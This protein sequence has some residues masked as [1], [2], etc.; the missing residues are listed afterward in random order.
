MIPPTCEAKLACGF[1]K[2]RKNRG[3]IEVSCVRSRIEKTV[4]KF[5]PENL[6]TQS[7]YWVFVEH[8]ANVLL[9]DCGGLSPPESYMCH[10]I[11]RRSFLR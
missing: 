3:E 2:Q 7:R 5:K 10:S 4:V 1:N 9:C 6:I 11:A 8:N